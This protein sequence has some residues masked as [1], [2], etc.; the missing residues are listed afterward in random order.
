MKVKT[1]LILGCLA[2]ASSVPEENHPTRDQRDEKKEQT[3]GL[4]TNYERVSAIP[5]R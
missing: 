5:V 4:A 2:Y 3:E 1:H